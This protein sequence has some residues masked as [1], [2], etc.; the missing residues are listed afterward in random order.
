MERDVRIWHQSMTDLTRLPGYSGML[1]EHALRVGDGELRVDLHGLDARTYADG[2]PP[3]AMCGYP[4]FQHLADVQI[5]EN[6]MAA[7]RAGY[8]AVAISCFVD[9]GLELARSVVDIP[10]VSSCETSLIVASAVGRSFGLITLDRA[11]VRILTTLVRSYGYA[12]R[13]VFLSAF[14][15]PVDEF[16]LDGAFKGSR[17]LIDRFTELARR[18][19]AAGADVIIP[20]EGV[21]NTVLVRN[22]VR[23]ID[24]TPVLDSYGSLLRFAHLLARMR[25]LTGLRTGRSGAYARPSPQIVD[26]IGR[27]TSDILIKCA[28]DAALV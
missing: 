7:E 11:M 4:W 25:E 27:L 16:E 19:I 20:A 22:G 23:D 12:D 26:G 5:V 6:A 10:V 9:P 21:L 24:G 2:V 15:P 17:A 14:D 1:R 18:A 28:R 13:V 8:D 3:V